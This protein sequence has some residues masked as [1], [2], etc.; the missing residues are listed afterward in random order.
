MSCNGDCGNCGEIVAPGAAVLNLTDQCNFRCKYCFVH[1]NP[2]RM[3][4]E[5]ARQACEYVLKSKAEVK[6]VSFF[7]GEPMLEFTAII[8]PLVE[9]FGDRI[10]FNITTNG[11]LLTEDI[12]DFFFDYDIPILLSIDGCKEV[13]NENRPFVDGSPSFDSV[14]KNIPY[15]LLKFPGTLFRATLT[16][17]SIPYMYKSY[18]FAEHMGFKHIA[19]IIN[20]DEEYEEE[21][22]YEM[23]RQYDRIILDILKGG[24]CWLDDLTKAKEYDQFPPEDMNIHRCGYG[25]TSIGVTVD[26]KITPCQELSSYDSCVIGDI[27][28]GIDREKH[29]Q[30]LEKVIKE[31]PLPEGLNAR[32]KRFLQNGFC[33]KHQYINNNFQATVGRVYQLKALSEVYTRFIKVITGS[34]N[35]IF[36]RIANDFS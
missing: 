20:E 19:F 16:K 33:P 2:R 26:G 28:N 17:F 8:K 36:R 10:R 34:N 5:T 14:V 7:G 21:D 23:T 32:E 11:S 24:Q 6:N 22:F 12:I 15:L 1:H 4:L 29:K 13:Q 25:T 31:T 35:L 9:E 27:V 18:K 3:K 30:F